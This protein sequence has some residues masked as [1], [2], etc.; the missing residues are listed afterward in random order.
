MTEYRTVVEQHRLLLLFSLPNISVSHPVNVELKKAAPIAEASN[1]LSVP[2]NAA[3]FSV[4][5]AFMSLQ[6]WDIWRYMR[7]RVVCT[8]VVYC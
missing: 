4:K 6:R 7:L 8:Q 5:F 3:N 2:L 1:L